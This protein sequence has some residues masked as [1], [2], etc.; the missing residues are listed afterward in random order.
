MENLR[1][2]NLDL[3]RITH[4]AL[5]AKLVSCE[6]CKIHFQRSVNERYCQYD[7]KEIIHYN[8]YNS[9]DGSNKLK[10]FYVDHLVVID[11]GLFSC[12]I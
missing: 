4:Q 11:V 1:N 6:P 2:N 7:E 5:D 9:H 3:Y 8:V 10:Y 12:H